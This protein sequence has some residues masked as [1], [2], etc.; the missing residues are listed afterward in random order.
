MQLWLR[1][2][3]LPSD[4]HFAFSGVGDGEGTLPGRGGG[5]WNGRGTN[6]H[7]VLE[8]ELTR[9]HHMVTGVQTFGNDRGVRMA[10]PK[11]NLTPSYGIVGIDDEYIRPLLANHDALGRY[12]YRVLE[13]RENQAQH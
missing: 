8:S 11:L 9:S 10:L 7:A 5:A 3:E 4:L 13:R 2:P 1:T 6:L 12:D